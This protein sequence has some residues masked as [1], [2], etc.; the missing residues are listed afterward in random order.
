MKL[1]LVKKDGV[2]FAAYPRRLSAEVYA[3]GMVTNQG[4]EIIEGDFVISSQPAVQAGVRES[5]LTIIQCDK[6][7]EGCFDSC[8]SWQPP[9]A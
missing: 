3:S 7:Y 6:R 8:P 4:V 1:F 9:A 5:C 2:A